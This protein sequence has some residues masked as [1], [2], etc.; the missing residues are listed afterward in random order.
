VEIVL[1]IAQIVALVSVSALCIYLINVLGQFRRD[2]SDFTQRSRPV[3]DN[4]AV[5]TENLKSAS[6]KI[7]DQVDI[8]RGSLQSFKE[9]ADNV[10]L[11]ERR[12]QDRIEEPIFQ[13][14]S[15]LGTVVNGLASFI[16]GLRG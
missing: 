12:V 11:F 10:L 15:V 13:V 3:L 1:I 14:A 16:K 8:V 5:I 4:L 2:V 7:D 6:E 9:V